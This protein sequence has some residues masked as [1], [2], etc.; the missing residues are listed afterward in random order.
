MVVHWKKAGN[1]AKARFIEKSLEHFTG[2]AAD[3]RLAKEITSFKV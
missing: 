2:H 1:E 3:H